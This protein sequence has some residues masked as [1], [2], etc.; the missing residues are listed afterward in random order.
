MLVRAMSP[1]QDLHQPTLAMSELL[2]RIARA[3]RPPLHHL[4]V[5]EARTLYAA[6]A[7]VLDLPRA[8]LSR[9]EDLTLPGP[10]GPLRARLYAA[11]QA[12]PPPALLFLH[13]GG[14]VVGGLNT[15]DSLCRQLAL[16][17]GCAVLALDYR[18]APEHR[19]PAALRDA[20][21]A[22][23]WLIAS[24]ADLGLDASVS[25]AMAGDSAGATLAASAALHAR[26]E[27]LPLAMQLLI[28]PGTAGGAIT[29]SMQRFARGH[30]LEA[31]TVHWFFAQARP[32]S[33]SPR[34]PDDD[35]DFAPLNAVSLAGVAPACVVLAGCDPLFDEGLAYARR[36]ESAGVPTRLHL[37]AGVTHNFIKMGRALPEAAVAL[38]VAAAAL[39]QAWNLP[40]NRPRGTTT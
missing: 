39:R 40:P 6:G 9:V 13:G 19:H 33:P 3:G 34:W 14:F 5:A 7:E 23:R 25:P 10:G 36:L 35:P 24:R 30:L 28:T 37:A 1:H 26:D 18:L 16:R 38:D 2:T 20:Q 31:A 15:H 32:Q 12:T 27:G 11:E 17:A 4:R 29:D 22:L 8:P 21:A